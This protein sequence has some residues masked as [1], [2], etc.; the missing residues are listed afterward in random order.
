MLYILILIAFGIFISAELK[1]I[2]PIPP[3]RQ[4][5]QVGVINNRINN[6]NKRSLYLQILNN[7][8][9]SNECKKISFIKVNLLKSLCYISLKD[10][11]YLSSIS[12]YIINLIY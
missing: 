7:I 1:K 6:I 3:H 8:C 2:M 4:L 9:W 5:G 12:D 10:I 11:Q